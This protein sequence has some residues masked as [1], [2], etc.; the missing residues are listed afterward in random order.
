MF[1]YY[2]GSIHFITIQNICGGRGGER[3]Q[4]RLIIINTYARTAITLLSYNECQD[5]GEV[6]CFETL[7]IL[8]MT[9]FDGGQRTDAKSE[10]PNGGR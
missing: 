6:F 5:H 4:G 2:M 3:R 1:L 8:L 7:Y 10:M 9:K